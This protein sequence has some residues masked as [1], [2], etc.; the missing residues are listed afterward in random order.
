MGAS[1]L[2]CTDRRSPYP[3]HGPP[4]VPTASQA[5]PDKEEGESL[6]PP[7][8]QRPE[9]INHRPS[10]LPRRPPFVYTQNRGATAFSAPG[11]CFPL[12]ARI[13]THTPGCK[14]CIVISEPIWASLSGPAGPTPVS[15]ADS[16]QPGLACSQLRVEGEGPSRQGATRLT[17]HP[18]PFPSP[19][20][21]KPEGSPRGPPL[22]HTP[23]P[24]DGGEGAA[25]VWGP[26][27]LRP[28]PPHPPGLHF[29]LHLVLSWLCFVREWDVG[30]WAGVLSQ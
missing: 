5:L 19:W 23:W 7:W 1:Q 16:S 8:S 4:S 20:E 27:S 21:G 10:P 6:R 30:P 18:P 29:S 15:T 17:G 12:Q 3:W 28:P 14:C 13:T 9:N 2:P 25:G 22:W 24:G 26:A 11:Q